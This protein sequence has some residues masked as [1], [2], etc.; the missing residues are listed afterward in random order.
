MSR[1]YILNLPV[2]VLEEI[3]G[4]VNIDTRLSL[5]RVSKLFHSFTIRSLYRDISLVNPS[6]LVACC[7]VLSSN[8]S[9]AVAVRTFSITYTPSEPPKTYYFS[10]FYAVIRR[11]IRCLSSLQH[12]RLMVFDPAYIQTLDHLTLPSLHHFE[13]YLTLTDSLISF[14]NRHPTISYL[15]IAPTEAFALPSLAGPPPRILLPQLQYFSGNSQ[16]ISA[17]ACDTALRAAFIFWDAVDASPQDAIT[18]LERTS[19]DGMNVLSCRRRGWNLDLLDL[20]SIWLPNIYTLSLTNL[21]VVDTHPSTAFLDAVKA[22]LPR[23]TMLRRLHINC[24]DVWK[25]GD[26]QCRMDD[27]FVTVTSWGAVCPSL[28]ECTL[29][30]SSNL[31]WLRVLDDLWFPDPSDPQGVAW[32][33]GMAYF[34]RYPQW[35]KIIR[36]IERMQSRTEIE[37]TI[38]RLRAL[39]IEA[40]ESSD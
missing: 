22:F 25:M 11:A 29:P 15:Q 35:N 16:C 9:A 6:A 28:M 3:A 8:L 5:C 40:D 34:R 14:L 24:V 7:H 32:L 17:L 12:L 39:L 37:G 26:V 19:S 1:P 20:I 23:F 21:L 13:C 38:E 10:S 31:K 30:H 2:E 18:A 27:D 33:L 4:V 36:I